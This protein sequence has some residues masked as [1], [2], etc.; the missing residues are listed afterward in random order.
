MRRYIY[1]F[2]AFVC[3]F[4]SAGDAWAIPPVLD[5]LSV[6]GYTESSV[7]LD[8]P[9]WTG[10]APDT[11]QA[12][13]G[14]DGTISEAGGVVSNSTEGPIDV[15]GSGYAF[16]GLTANTTY[17]IIV[18]ATNID[19]YS[20][21]QTTQLTSRTPVLNALSVGSYTES[22]VALDQPTFS[23]TGLPAPVTVQAYIGLDGTISEAGGVVSNSTEG[24]I[25]VSGSGYNFS[26]LTANT[27]YRVIVV[28]TN[29]NGEY[30]VEQTTQLTSRTPVLNALSVGSYTES[31]VALDQP[32]FSTT[33]LPAPVTVQAY[34][35]LDGTISEAGGVVSNSTE[36][37]IDV[38]G[39][40][41]NFSGL[42]ANTTYRVIVVATNANGEYDVEQTTQLTSRT[43]VLNAL[44]L[45]AFDRTSITLDQPTF[46]TTGL[47]APVTVQAYIGLVG[48]ISEAGGVVSNSTQGPIDVSGSGYTFIGLTEDTNYRIIVIARNANNEYD[49]EQIDQRTAFLNVTLNAPPAGSVTVDGSEYYTAG[50][51]YDLVLNVT[52]NEDAWASITQI[53]FNFGPKTIIINSP[54]GSD[55]TGLTYAADP[56]ENVSYTITGVSNNFQIT[57]T[58]A[59][60][61]V[62]GGS[63]ADIPGAA[64]SISVDMTTARYGN[65]S[66]ASFA[67]TFGIVTDGIKT[68]VT[69]AATGTSVDLAEYYL[70]PPSSY[71]FTVSGTANGHSWACL[72]DVR[73]SIPRDGG[74]DLLFS[75]NPT[76]A[77]G[78]STDINGSGETAS[79]TRGGTYDNFS[80]V[81]AYA[82]TANTAA[83]DTALGPHNVTGSA[84]SAI[85]AGAES[86]VDNHTYGI[87]TRGIITNTA[88]IT[89]GAD[90]TQIGTPA[91]NYFLPSRNYVFTASVT[92]NGHS[93]ACVTD[94]TL[95][96]PVDAVPANDILLSFNPT[97]LGPV[98]VTAATGGGSFTAVVG[99]L[100]YNDFNVTFTYTPDWTLTA[101]AVGGR[102]IRSTA[103][104]AFYAA[105]P[106]TSA[107]VAHTYGICTSAKVI[108]AQD[109]NAADGLVNPWDATFNVSGGIVYN[110]AAATIADLVTPDT[111]ITVNPILVYSYNA[112]ANTDTAVT[113]AN[114][115]STL[116]LA[117]PAAW[118]SG[119]GIPNDGIGPYTWRVR[120][121]IAGVNQV[122]VPD[123]ALDVDCDKIEI[124]D[125]EFQSGGGYS[126]NAPVYNRN[127]YT[128]GTQVRVQT[129]M[130]YGGGNTTV[131][132]NLTVSYDYTGGGRTTTVTVPANNAWSGWV[133][134]EN[135]SSGEAAA[136]GTLS[137]AGYEVSV[138]A[139]TGGIF[140]GTGQNVVARIVQDPT[141]PTILWDNAD[142]PGANTTP[143]TGFAAGTIG[144]DTI[145]FTWTP[146]A[147]DLAAAGDDADFY[148]YRV[149]YKPTASATW[150]M[151][152][153][154]L[155]P[156]S[157]GLIGT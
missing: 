129:R 52:N 9:T 127:I 60:S 93:W 110:I 20:V 12:Y 137:F 114:S 72:T 62:A 88:A 57:L 43:P 17:R 36:G 26:G 38:S 13:I 34:I 102:N 74:A 107:N 1:I 69:A 149:Y 6:G 70:S 118:F 145:E 155:Y 128:A 73:I 42:T 65:K 152:D 84:T 56:G 31:S 18:V 46:S 59:L 22:S 92:A 124:I 40:G 108:I 133:E 98:G 106:V 78:T 113:D 146:I 87:A 32:T 44:S 68:V 157:L 53:Q 61:A 140:G 14:L 95:R 91:A 16:S 123:T 64:R 54:D 117:V 47:P 139:G 97:G 136:G 41:Y 150:A 55:N 50:N 119:N 134:I 138:A 8:Q 51:S 101:A 48:T 86:D 81:F 156:A 82:P 126:A 151:V 104:S 116:N 63:A 30:D 19:G 121:T 96:I 45:S 76:S 85:I 144:A 58:Y 115:D 29:A 120:T 10:G 153:R 21:E 100:D 25:D 94:V 112:G 105:T 125:M 3:L 66:S 130:Q 11:V 147:A 141:P 15:S 33:G 23:T 37:P 7:T 39:S 90:T 131:A 79:Y 109:G 122:L 142:P 75:M 154:T 49:V 83:L 77:S 5:A 28:A 35:G 24:P 103:T 80:I 89:T 111:D 2:A 4:L 143:L 135:P 27:T 132:A 99:G 67:R 148:S 71:N